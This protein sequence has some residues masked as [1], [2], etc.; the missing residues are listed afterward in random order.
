MLDLVPL[1]GA[2]AGFDMNRLPRLSV[3]VK[4]DTTLAAMAADGS[5]LSLGAFPS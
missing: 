2:Q 4:K 3:A 5:R 1:T